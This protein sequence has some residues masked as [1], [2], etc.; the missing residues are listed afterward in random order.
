MLYV[1]TTKL[2]ITVTL[3]TVDITIKYSKVKLF[4]TPM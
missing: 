3:V 2:T 1:G 4:Y